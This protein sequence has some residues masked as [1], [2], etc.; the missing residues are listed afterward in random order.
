[1]LPLIHFKS[2]PFE[3]EERIGRMTNTRREKRKKIR[4]KCPSGPFF[5]FS[6]FHDN[7]E[8]FPQPIAEKCGISKKKN[9]SAN[10]SAKGVNLQNGG[11]EGSRTL[12]LYVAN[13][14]L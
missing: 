5:P 9:P 14:S 4:R 11:A 13:V 6:V 7:I 2:F 12:D 3:L 1:M 8:R 10:R